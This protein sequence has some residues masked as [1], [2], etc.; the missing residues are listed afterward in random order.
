MNIDRSVNDKL[1]AKAKSDAIVVDDTRVRT[2]DAAEFAGLSRTQ[3]TTNHQLTPRDRLGLYKTRGWHG[4]GEVIDEGLS[5]EDAVKRYLGWWVEEHAVFAEI[6]GV[7]KPLPAKVTV[8]SD[9]REILGMVA[10]DYVVVQNLQMG[11]IADSIVGQDAAVTMETCGSLLAGRKVFLTL[12]VPREVRVGKTGEDVSVAFL[13]LSSAHD[14]SAALSASWCFDRV[15]CNNTLTSALA[16]IDARVE[17]GTAFRI[18]H[19]GD[20]QGAIVEARKI[21]GIAS[22]GLDRYEEIAKQL[23]S[24]FPKAGGVDR[25]FR[26]AYASI[27][28]EV[29]DEDAPEQKEQDEI[30]RIRRNRIVEEWH[31]AMGQEEQ[32][33]DGIGGSLW[34]AFNAVSGWQDHK[35]MSDG[36]ASDRRI[37]SNLLG[38]SSL[39]KRKALRTALAFVEA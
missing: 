30:A 21:L 23:S 7:R 19:S 36:V 5:G 37:H 33:L 34:A 3:R 22:R 13:L 38:V 28:G 26:M 24:V 11:K 39:A 6:D 10:A 12:R 4:L 25:Y 16:G 9:T 15:V 2:Y 31:A 18:R 1:S 27:Y 17:A 8:R 20:V 35:R 32:R 14:G 29:K